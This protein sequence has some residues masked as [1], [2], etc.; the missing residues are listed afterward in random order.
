MMF[1]HGLSYFFGILVD[2]GEIFDRPLR[3]E[4]DPIAI[5][6]EFMVFCI[7][8]RKRMKK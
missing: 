5:L 2:F 6:A 7:F 1:S 4:K 3:A 8:R